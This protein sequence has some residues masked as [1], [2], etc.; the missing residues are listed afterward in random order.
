MVFAECLK[1]SAKN[2]IPVV[3]RGGRDVANRRD[4]TIMHFHP[5]E[6]YIKCGVGLDRRTVVFGRPMT[7][8][9]IKMR[10]N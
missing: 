5:R 3:N 8:K 2:A 7:I 4:A 1:Y 10:P 6:G 9:R